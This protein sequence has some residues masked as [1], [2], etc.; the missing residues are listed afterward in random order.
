M[1]E[2][3]PVKRKTPYSLVDVNSVRIDSI[4][5]SRAGQ[6]C[7]AG[8]DVAKHELVVCLYWPD[9][10]F[11]RP[12][13]VKCPSQVRELVGK[14]AELSA[15]CPLVVAMESSGTYGDVLRQAVADAGIEVHRVS[16]KAV[17]DHCETFD[18]VSSQHDGKDAAIIGELC[19]MGK[20]VVWPWSQRC[21][22]DQEMRYW[23]RKLD[24]AQRIR[25]VYY[26]KLEGL[27]A[28][29]WPEATGLLKLTSVTLVDALARW[30]D[31]RELAGDPQAAAVLKELG[32]Y[33][34]TAEKVEQVIESARTTLGVL[35][36]PWQVRELRAVAAQIALRRREVDE[37]KCHLRRLAKHHPTIQA[38][39]PAIGLVTACVLWMCLGDVANY[40][41]AAAY[42]KA[43][44]LNLKERSSGKH[45]GELS[46]SK[47]GQRLTR[48]W[49]YFSAL[50]WFKEPGVKEW[51]RR[52]K[53]RDGG[54]GSKAA[55]AV[56]RRLAL[57]A[58]H[59]GKNGVAFDP[60][61]LFP[62]TK[63]H[64]AKAREMTTVQ[65]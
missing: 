19:W 17:K 40:G 44:G 34:L 58:Y 10:N 55:V 8:V 45:K 6:K 21:E 56:M 64:V 20:S 9:R 61:R 16:S 49:L 52:K 15:H 32:G 42:R 14:L 62:G 48:K 60:A 39:R 30:G 18:G 5:Q 47:R 13:R 53:E 51:V 25:Q 35:M 33:Y 23:I 26:G 29:H 7:I 2:V 11:D 41:S 1:Q 54:K 12:W 50:R 22:Q 59:V 57:A 28:R 4:V 3:I 65:T 38:Q 46:L 27:L 37:C 36:N 31:P 43:M 24:T 63:Q